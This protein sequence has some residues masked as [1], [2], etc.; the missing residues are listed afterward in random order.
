MPRFGGIDPGGFPCRN[1]APTTEQTVPSLVR[2][3][4]ALY[5]P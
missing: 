5:Q 4:N 1:G 2:R 3:Y